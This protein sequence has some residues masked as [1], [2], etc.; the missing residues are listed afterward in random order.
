[1][2]DDR[3]ATIAATEV[4]IPPQVIAEHPWW[5]AH[6]DRINTAFAADATIASLCSRL[7]ALAAALR[8][9]VGEEPILAVDMI[10]NAF[11]V[12]CGAYLSAPHA[13]DCSWVL[14]RAAIRKSETLVR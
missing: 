10:G 11:C 5:Q 9:I 6:R 14:A 1:M 7:G 8:E 12:F 4:W 13:D 3:D 2:T